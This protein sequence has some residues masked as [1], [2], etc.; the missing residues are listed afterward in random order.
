[1]NTR[2]LH[3]N[4]IG[5]YFSKKHLF[6]VESDEPESLE[7][8]E[9]QYNTI[10][11]I[12]FSNNLNEIVGERVTDKTTRNVLYLPET[13]LYSDDLNKFQS[14][15]KINEIKRMFNM[16]FLQPQDVTKIMFNNSII[17]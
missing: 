8:L 6:L 4:Q 3:Y 11:I 16:V 17:L 5:R 2:L 14:Q 9:N 10:T 1:M 7:M 12:N 15:Y 13:L